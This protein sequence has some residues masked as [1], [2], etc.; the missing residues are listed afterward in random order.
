MAII[1]AKVGLITQWVI[2][3]L[4][5]AAMV[6]NP[7]FFLA[8]YKLD[9]TTMTSQEQIILG[10][11]IQF[12][13]TIQFMQCAMCAITNRNGNDD[14]KATLA[15]MVGVG[16]IPQIIS[17]FVCIPWFA[18]LGVPASGMYFNA[19]L[20]ALIG[21]LCLL[22]ADFPPAIKIAP[23]SKPIYW[24][25][26]AL[27]L[28]FGLYMFAML[29]DAEALAAGYGIKLD[30]KAKHVMVGLMRYAFPPNFFCMI[31]QYASHILT[32]GSHATYCL[33]R[34]L[35][36]LSF[37]LFL[38]QATSAANWTALNTDSKLDQVVAGQKVNA[39]QWL[40][41]F[42]LFYVPIVM[43]SD[44]IKSAVETEVEGKAASTLLASSGE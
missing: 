7:S 17:A 12:L 38:S 30:G 39:Y 36:A 16:C 11:M 15:L 42:V 4:F 2:S 32:V 37:G 33:N 3:Y 18:E 40:F 25:S 44:S 28:N 29:F 43:L 5:G 41:F 9:L 26:I 27:S 10:S 24:G 21:L 8:A 13:G 34:M 14:Q 20:Y 19:A 6:M 35:C 31:L 1:P 22:G 23:V